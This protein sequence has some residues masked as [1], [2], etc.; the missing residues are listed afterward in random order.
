MPHL[1]LPITPSGP[2]LEIICGVSKPRAEALAKAGRPIPNPVPARALI[3]TGASITALDSTILKA[4]GA[5]CKGTVPLHTPSTQ[6]GSPHVA[7][8]FDVS[9]VLVHPLLTRTWRALPVIESALAHQGI[10]ALI[11]RDILGFCLMTYDGQA[12]TFSLGF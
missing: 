1:T 2:L 6:S 10:L 11:G 3:D 12:G 8:Q 9:L 5:V 4:L 7:N